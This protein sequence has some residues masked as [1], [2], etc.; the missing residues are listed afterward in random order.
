MENVELFNFRVWPT[1]VSIKIVLNNIYSTV[2]LRLKI[3]R[4]VSNLDLVIHFIVDL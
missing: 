3:S 1:A 2:V 4:L